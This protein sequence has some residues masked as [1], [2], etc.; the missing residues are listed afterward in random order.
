MKHKR[1]M[2]I[3]DIKKRAGSMVACGVVALSVSTA[4]A[5]APYLTESLQ[6]SDASG[7]L[8]RA[9]CMMTDKNYVG[10]IDQL[11]QIRNFSVNLL[12]DNTLQE[13]DYLLAMAYYER[14][15]EECVEMLR[16]YLKDYPSAQNALQA[17]LTLGDYHFY[18]G[19]YDRAV[20]TYNEVDFD[21]LNASMR[22]AY[23]YRKGLALTKV[24]LFDEARPLFRALLKDSEYG[25][26]AQFYVAYLDYVAEDYDKALEG[27]RKV[28]N[29]VAGHTQRQ[30]K[31]RNWEYT[32]TGL[33]AGYYITH[34]EYHKGQYQDVIDHGRDLMQKSP[35]KE[36]LPEMNRVVGESYYK[37]GIESVAAQY[38]E[39]YLNATEYPVNTAVYTMGVIEYNRGDYE[40]AAERF[41]SLTD[42]NNNVTQ[43]SYL[44][45]G[46]CL[47]RKGDN[48]AAAIAF[49]KAYKMDYDFKVCETALYNYAVACT[50]GGHVPFASSIDLL[51][52]FIDLYPRS[53]YAAAVDEYLATVYYKDHD[54]TR[55]LTSINRIASPSAKVLAAKQKV[56]YALGVEALSNGRYADAV[57]YMTDASVM[58]D[59]DRMLAT[60]ALLWKGDAHYATGDH[61][62]ALQAYNAYLKNAKS[63]DANYA[64]A[65]YK[66][67]YAQYM[68]HDFRSAQSTFAK[69]APK[70]SATLAADAVLR[71]ADCSYYIGRPTEALKG[72]AD[73]IKKGCKTA[74]YA[75]LQHANMQGMLGKNSQKISELNKF[76]SDYP[77]SKWLPEAMLEKAQTYVEM[78]RSGDAVEVYRDLMAQY[79]MTTEAREGTLQMAITLS[80]MG[81]ST[82]AEDAYR[83]VIR[84]WPTSEQASSANDDL[85]RIYAGRGELQEYR[86][87]LASIPNSPQLNDDDMEQLTFEAAESD[88]TD[89][90][91]NIAKM[92]QYVEQYPSGKYLAS[93]LYYIASYHRTHEQYAEALSAL[94][95][96]ISSRGDSNYVLPALSMKGQVM[97][98]GVLGEPMDI[99]K[100]YKELELRGGAEYAAQAYAGVMRNSQSAAD[101][102]EY[103][104]KLLSLSGLTTE[105][106]EEARYYHAQA[107]IELGKKSQAEEDLKSLMVN[108]KSLY[109]SKAA[110]ELGELYLADSRLDEAE[111]VLTDFTDEGTPHQY[112]LARGFIALTDVYHAKGQVSLAKEYIRSLQE[113]Y[114]GDEPDIHD[115]INQRLNN[116]K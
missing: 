43:S 95:T 72:Y 41:R 100:V 106:Q 76:I 94:N 18:A 20:Q 47:M 59:C 103:A 17:R 6:N 74:D 91:D 71:A 39:T 23:S 38:L 62:Q 19:E 40:R 56:L 54:Y 101:R 21:R 84:R 55:A 7:Y 104:Q 88:L 45:L 10:A 109:G 30:G 8:S 53:K 42:G 49:E 112:W 4:V 13:C 34:I 60:Q 58:T 12:T 63:S 108:V 67:A 107:S 61:K 102:L 79:P 73:A 114:P 32:P 81:R 97:E 78:G 52:D 44:Y 33:E 36:L 2:T 116:W 27:F 22:K 64:Q 48:S 77:E 25:N 80:N 51:E 50:A 85:R 69:A 86:K 87:F 16:K 115:M 15:E 65:L 31:K 68:L 3:H 93:A 110:V 14:G 5:S 105:E 24:G 98:Q 70:L 29:T 92:Q 90:A 26:A 35:V 83:E 66:T 82:E 11:N 9:R 57:G 28:D 113:N 46:Q 75:A 99:V 111:K 37:T 1:Q 96:L 89:N